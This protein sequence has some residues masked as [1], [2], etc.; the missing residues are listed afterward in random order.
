VGTR[1]AYV[2]IL[3]HSLAVPPFTCDASRTHPSVRASPHMGDAQWRSCLAR[4]LGRSGKT[5][6]QFA[7]YQ[8]RQ[9]VGDSRRGN[10]RLGDRA[11]RATSALSANTDAHASAP[12]GD[13]HLRIGRASGHASGE[14]RELRVRLD[15]AEQ[16]VADAHQIMDLRRRLDAEAVERRRLTALLVDQ[17]PA[18]PAASPEPAPTRRWWPWRRSR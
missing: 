6:P 13:A 16:R 1:L 8:D 7:G 11:R 2:R 15:A 14:I 10:R 3:L 18:P 17:R 4:P 9:A 12:Q 5:A